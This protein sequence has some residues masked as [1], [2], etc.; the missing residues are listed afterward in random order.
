MAE[1]EE[2]ATQDKRAITLSELGEHFSSLLGPLADILNHMR[3]LNE[4]AKG[5]LAQSKEVVSALRDN[6]RRL[7]LLLVFVG[8]CLIS[9]SYLLIRIHLLTLQ[10]T[11]TQRN[12]SE[13]QGDL[14]SV[15]FSITQTK[16][17]IAHTDRSVKERTSQVSLERRD[18][19]VS[20]I[21]RPPSRSR[22]RRRPHTEVVLPVA[23]P[24]TLK[25]EEDDS[26]DG[27][28]GGPRP[29]KLEKR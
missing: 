12:L 3:G 16:D 15:R 9:A 5:Q 28:D 2:K 13:I 23:V 17:S 22:A 7:L 14:E 19:G 20:V 25:V 10:L 8:L 27:P 11:G 6:N 1:K 4:H 24:S 21:I 26:I 18:G 29:L